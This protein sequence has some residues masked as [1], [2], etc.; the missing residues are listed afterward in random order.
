MTGE[1]ADA[2]AALPSGAWF[3]S[4]AEGEVRWMGETRT[5][6]L[7]TGGTT[8]GRFCLVDE[9]ARR[10]E[11]IPLHRHPEDV[12]SF[13]VLEGEIDFHLGVQ[14]AIRAGAHA[15]L[16]VPAGVVHGFRIASETA[17]Y[18]ILTTA[19]HGEFYRAISAPADAGGRP[20]AGEVDW[21]RV[22][23]TAQAFGIEVVGELPDP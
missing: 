23:A 21:D 17:R 7:A 22:M 20:P 13:Y 8:D 14:P 3:R 19:R 12:E 10:G 15:F 16:H 9:T 5:R 6:F 11:A 4:A 2:P 1:T 18:L